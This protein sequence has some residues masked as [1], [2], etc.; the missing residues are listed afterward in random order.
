MDIH[1]LNIQFYLS[2]ESMLNSYITYNLLDAKHWR[3]AYLPVENA[4]MDQR[5][6]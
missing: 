3:K 2:L 4:N 5:E 6:T 1:C